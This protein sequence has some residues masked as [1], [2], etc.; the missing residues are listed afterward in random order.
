LPWGELVAVNTDTQKIAWRVP[1]GI[2]EG[3]GSKSLTTGTSNLGG[4]MT[5]KSGLVFIGAT[6]D[7]H[8][9][10]FDAK[11]GKV[12]WDT[13]LE[14]SGAATPI[15]FMGGDGKQYVVIAAGGG[16]SVGQ[17]VMSDTLVAYRL[18]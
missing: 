5:T 13:T 18:P 12:L 4:S 14:A 16:T 15:S 7:R 11:T 8:F 17:K 2:T 1:L 6:N 10:A 3:I 9:R